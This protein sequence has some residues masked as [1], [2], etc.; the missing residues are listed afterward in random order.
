MVVAELHVP[1][2]MSVGAKTFDLFLSLSA[3]SISLSL[4]FSLSNVYSPHPQGGECLGVV[5]AELH[6]SQGVAVGARTVNLG[7]GACTRGKCGHEYCC[8]RMGGRGRLG[9]L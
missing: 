5:V 9:L 3:V 8:C 7:R 6:V 4:V 2:D 1:K